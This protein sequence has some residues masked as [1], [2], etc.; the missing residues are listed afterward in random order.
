LKIGTPSNFHVISATGAGSLS[1]GGRSPLSS[2]ASGQL[3]QISAYFCV[4]IT[5]YT[6]VCHC[7][8]AC[9]HPSWHSAGYDV[10]GPDRE[11]GTRV[12]DG[13]TSLLPFERGATGAQVPLQNS[14]IRSL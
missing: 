11:A 3:W 8:V 13:D 10:G 12:N 9:P 5:R 1:Q 14:I 6:P 7:G 2:L 4:E